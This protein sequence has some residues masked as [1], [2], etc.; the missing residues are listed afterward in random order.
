[1]SDNPLINCFEEIIGDKFENDFFISDP[2][3]SFA[4][5]AGLQVLQDDFPLERGEVDFLKPL[6]STKTLV[7]NNGLGEGKSIGMIYMYSLPGDCSL[8]PSPLKVLKG[9]HWEFDLVIDCRDQL[10]ALGFT[11]ILIPGVDY[12]PK[13][14]HAD[15]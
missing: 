5:E 1:M 13:K 14:S 2:I 10:E 3:S 9:T 11:K 7:L 8:P 15:A 4:F 12:T 6:G